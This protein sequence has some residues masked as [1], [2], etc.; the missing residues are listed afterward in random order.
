MFE[1]SLNVIL[2]LGLRMFPNTSFNL[3]LEMHTSHLNFN[4]VQSSKSVLGFDF[5]ISFTG[6]E[7]VDLEEKLIESESK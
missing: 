1:I 2:F 7:T 6:K 4:F 5:S 3:N